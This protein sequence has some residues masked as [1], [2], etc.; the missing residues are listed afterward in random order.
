M[1][2]NGAV[3]MPKERAPATRTSRSVGS[4]VQSFREQP[5]A[6][7][8]LEES[9]RRVEEPEVHD[10][11][12]A[13]KDDEGA[14]AEGAPRVGDETAGGEKPRDV[15]GLHPEPARGDAA[16]SVDKEPAVVAV[17]ARGEVELRERVQA[18]RLEDVE[19][20]GA[21]HEAKG[22]EEGDR[23]HHPGEDVDELPQRRE[24]RE[25]V[26][27]RLEDHVKRR[28]Q[29]DAPDAVDEIHD[30]SGAEEGLVRDDLL[31]RGVRV[32][33]DVQ[34]FV[35]REICDH[36]DEEGEEVEEACDFGCGSLCG[37]DHFCPLATDYETRLSAAA[38]SFASG[39]SFWA[40]A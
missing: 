34:L 15:A 22:V 32:A 2:L 11:L 26:A 35:N 20:V 24:D 21:F 16:E 12:E 10:L 23:H 5:N 39:S 8:D 13:R 1:R 7:E 3:N 37:G 28:E 33:D 14:G 9:H 4:I 6:D 17:E 19:G 29:D 18:V 27:D 25:T 38:T 31:R 40:F 36:D 30:D